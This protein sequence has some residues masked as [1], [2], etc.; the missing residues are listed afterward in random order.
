[1]CHYYNIVKPVSVQLHRVFSVSKHFYCKEFQFV[2]QGVNFLLKWVMCF[3]N[4]KILKLDCIS[5]SKVLSTQNRH[6]QIKICF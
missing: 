1:M 5:M 3:W 2:K 4:N 6:K